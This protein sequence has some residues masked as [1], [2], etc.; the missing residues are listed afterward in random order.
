MKFQRKKF[1]F[2]FVFNI[3]CEQLIRL[4]VPILFANLAND[5][6]SSSSSSSLQRFGEPSKLSII[7]STLIRCFDV[8]MLCKPRQVRMNKNIFFY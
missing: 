4:N 7:L 6:T 2:Y 1:L 8:S 3:K 5:D